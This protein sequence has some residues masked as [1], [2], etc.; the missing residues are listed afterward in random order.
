MK[1]NNWTNKEVMAILEGLKFGGD[2]NNEYDDGLSD[3]IHAFY[4]F[5]RPDGE[6]GAM[7]MTEE[8]EVVHVGALLP[9]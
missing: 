5:D 9:R 6:A 7:A 8:G 2:R 3:A 4:D 1:R